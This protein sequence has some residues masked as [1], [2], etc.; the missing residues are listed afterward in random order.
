MSKEILFGEDARRS[1]ERLSLIHI[2]CQNGAVGRK[3]RRNDFG[4]NG[5]ALG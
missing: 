5:Q 4:G 3:P 1:L 2:F